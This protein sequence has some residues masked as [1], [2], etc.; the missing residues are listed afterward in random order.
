MLRS[1][2]VLL[3]PILLIGA[4]LRACG[5]SA[6]TVVDA[7]PAIDTARAADL[8]PVVVPSGLPEGWQPVQ[9]TFRR[10]EDGTGG[11][12]RLG[13]LT[14]SGGQVLLVVSNEDTSILI[15][16]EL[17]EDSRSQGEVLVDGQAWGSAV[18]R[19]NERSL[20]RTETVRSGEGQTVRTV[21]VVGRAPLDELT[22]LAGSL[23]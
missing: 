6:P 15:E 3:I 2:A 8:F 22:T 12:L 1:L 18:V 17:G 10:T 19:G 21:I 13:Y 16:R 4:L 7:G 23:Q 5:S 9:A 14:P 20:V 11:S